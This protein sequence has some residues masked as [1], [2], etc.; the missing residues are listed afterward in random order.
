M[1]SHDQGL[2][3]GPAVAADNCSA[4]ASSAPE[5]KTPAVVDL[6]KHLRE[7]FVN[8]KVF[9]AMTGSC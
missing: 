4:S 9:F 2:G 8:I 6:R 1:R 7:T 5:D 3:V